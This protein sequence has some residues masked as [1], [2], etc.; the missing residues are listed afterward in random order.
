MKI[1][2]DIYAAV[3]DDLDLVARV[4][5]RRSG[6]ELEKRDEYD[7]GGTIYELAREGHEYIRIYRNWNPEDN[8]WNI[9]PLRQY[10]IFIEI[11]EWPDQAEL[12]KVVPSIKE[13]PVELVYR[14]EL[15]RDTGRVN[16]I[17]S[18]AP[19]YADNSDLSD[20]DQSG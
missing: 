2:S 14:S 6:I 9:Y 15:D 19:A 11:S 7:F 1:L 12:A 8:D 5:M 10:P 13:F 4:F 20:S 17:Y 18:A 16:V 3:T